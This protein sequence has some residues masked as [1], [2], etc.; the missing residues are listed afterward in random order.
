MPSG[1]SFIPRRE[2]FWGAEFDFRVPSRLHPA[3]PVIYRVLYLPVCCS[4]FFKCLAHASA[5][6]WKLL[7]P[8]FFTL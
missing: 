2:G 5:L 6:D 1:L 4:Q 8:P 3:L 7:D